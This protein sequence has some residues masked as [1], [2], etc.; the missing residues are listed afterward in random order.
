L[1][2]LFPRESKVTNFK[3]TVVVNEEILGLQ[4]TM[5]NTGGVD[6]FQSSLTQSARRFFI[7]Y[8][9]DIPGFDK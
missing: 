8:V 5:D 9:I 1:V 4:V 2:V 6:E 7:Y 3:I